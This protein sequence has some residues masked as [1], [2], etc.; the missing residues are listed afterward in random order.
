M[1]KKKVL[2]TTIMFVV[3]VAAIIGFKSIFGDENTLVG[4]AGITAALSLLGTDYTINPLRNTVY[5]VGLEVVLGVGAFLAANNSI[6]ALIITFILIF[7]VLYNFTYNTKKPT[8]VAFTL[9]YL[10]MLYSPVDVEELPTRIVALAFCGLAIMAIQMIANKNKLK[11]QSKKTI[12]SSIEYIGEEIN[13]I[14]EN[15]NLDFVNELNKKTYIGIRDLV[16]DMYKR[17]DKDI[18]LPIEIMQSLF[19]SRF[20]ESINLTVG[21]IKDDKNDNEG[22]FKTLNEVKNLLVEIDNFTNENLS[23]DELINKLSEYAEDSDKIEPNYYLIYE[24]KDAADLL[25][26]DLKDSRDKK[27]DKI[28]ENYF[29]TDLLDRVNDLKNNMSKDSLKFTFALRGAIVTSIGV[30]IV[31]IFNLE[32]GKWLVFSLSSIVQPYLEA[33]KVKGKDRLVGTVIGLV[34]F[35]ILFYL[36]KDNSAR[37]LVILAVGY[38]SNFQTKYKDQM[39]CTTISALGAAAMT[40]SLEM[41]SINRLVFVV[42]GTLI[43]LYA[44]KVI[45]P[46][47]MIDITKKDIEKSIMINEKVLSKLYELGRLELKIDEDVKEMLFVNNLINKKIDTNNLTL[48]SNSIDDFLYNQR[49]FMNDIRFL[50]NNFRRFSKNN[51]GVMDLVYDVDKLMH[52]ENS[53][54]DIIKCFNKRADKFSQLVLVDVLELKENIINSKKLS[55]QISNEL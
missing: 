4:V 35:E 33:S 7:T 45:L 26:Y 32:Y 25:S 14:L 1:E 42:I 5:F 40:S 17:I 43:A 11:T 31:S 6:L 46:Y 29:V 3:I 8:Y 22:Y 38:I 12:K 47:K 13:C 28:K 53:K 27:I 36:I 51:T 55:K 44:N 16:S 24:L 34:I 2:S 21:K 23:I 30:F 39:I 37:V 41:I 54:E 20:L 52:R 15:K 18:H 10:F 48:L 19:I 9:G 50:V 49:M